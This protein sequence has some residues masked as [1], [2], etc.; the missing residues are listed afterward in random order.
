MT[1]IEYYAINLED[2]FSGICI[3]YT[4]NDAF[5]FTSILP[6]TCRNIIHFPY[7]HPCK[8]SDKWNTLSFFLLTI[9]HFGR[10]WWSSEAYTLPDIVFFVEYSLLVAFYGGNGS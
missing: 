5:A 10:A 1:N 6:I 4:I 9:K 2:N 3:M 8:I 7:R